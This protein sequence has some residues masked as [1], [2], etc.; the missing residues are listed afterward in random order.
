MSAKVALITGCSSGIGKSLAEEAQRRGFIVYATARK[1]ESLQALRQKNTYTLRLDITEQDS[2][3]EAIAIIQE[4]SGRIDYLINNAGQSLFGPL[5][6]IPLE[7]VTQL[8]NTNLT[9]Q[10]AMC[11]AV[12]PLMAAAHS[13]CIVNIGSMVGVVTTPF[14]GVYSASKAALHLLSET[15]RMEVAPLG[16]KVVVVQPGAVRSQVAYSA[17]QSSELERYQQNNSLYHSVHQ[18]ILRRAQASQDQPMASEVFASRVWNRLSKTSPPSVIRVGKGVGVLR[19][20]AL[21]PRSIRDGILCR[22]FGINEL[23]I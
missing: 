12:I 9:S 6:E 13:G 4:Q 18:H 19:I 22:H 8:L 14:V 15:L 2:I 11:Q 23:K 16:I 17:T 5:A 20:L 10:L 7:K 1:P 21:L 3:Q